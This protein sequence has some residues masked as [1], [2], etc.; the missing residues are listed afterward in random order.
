MEQNQLSPHDIQEL[1]FVTEEAILEGFES[2]KFLLG[3]N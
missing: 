1:V 2:D 3:P